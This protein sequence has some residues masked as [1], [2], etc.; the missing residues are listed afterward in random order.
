MTL[1]NTIKAKFIVNLAAAVGA[2]LMSVIVAYFIAV[3]SIKEIMT[4]DLN[5]VA[6]ALE[7]NINFIA[8][9]E[10][11]GYEDSKFKDEIKKIKI[12]KSGYVYFINAEGVMT[13]HPKPEDEGQNKAGHDYVDHIRSDK[14][15]GIYEY[16]SATTGQDKIAAYRY[17]P[18][19]DMWVIPG[20]NKADYFDELKASFFKWFLLLG[21][22]LTAILIAINYFSGTSILHPIEEL[23]HVSSDLAH[24]N[25]DLTK[26]LPILNK[27]DEIGIASHYLNQ[28]IGKIQ[29]TI[30]DTK[31][32]TVSAVGST[33][34]LN[35]AAT[36]LSAQSEKTNLI[37]QNTNSTAAE[38]GATLEQSVSMAKDT[39]INSQSTEKELGHVR[40]IANVITR[41][42][43]NTT[44]MSNELSERFAQLSSDAASVS[45]VLSIIS[46]IADQTNLLAL[47]AAI[48][49]ARA[50][51]HGRGFAVVADEV[52]KLA[53]RTQK[54]LT[55]INSTISI[56]IQSISDSS[57]MM[58]TN[59]E[60]IER[61]AEQSEEIDAKIDSASTVLRANVDASR[62]S[63]E[64]AENMA[65]KIKEIIAKVSEMSNLSESNQKEIQQISKIAS[66][67]YDSATNLNTQLG[68]FKS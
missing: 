17:I 27:N 26:R 21:T 63:V 40:E 43:H 50:G 19:W 39:L 46:D 25:G 58:N 36:N 48:E 38:I 37:A 57:D 9:L 68:Q 4:S 62:K 31:R 23:D 15:G 14:A 13:I 1:F 24:G 53:E 18:A 52:R 32:I 55:E 11:K 44:Q 29:T 56:V 66:E 60:N 42:I 45:G 10:P 12:G 34:T 2:I 51:E 16:V 33:S 61:L 6:D 65:R 22:I 28:F 47:N 59:S 54:S 5:T 35:T 30:N 64:E 3:G 8:E 20:I 7:K 49:A 67:L 41:E